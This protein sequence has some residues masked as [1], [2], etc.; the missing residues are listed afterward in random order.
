MGFTA[1][2]IKELNEKI[3]YQVVFIDKLREE[4]GKVIIG[5]HYMLDRLLI[6]LL[7]NGTFFS[8][9]FRALQKHLPSNHCRRPFMRNSAGYSLLLICCLPM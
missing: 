3:Q 8:K 5:Q 7:T 1:D 6:G 9:V 2:D 4:V